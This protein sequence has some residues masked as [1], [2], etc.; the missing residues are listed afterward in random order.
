MNSTRLI[1]CIA[2]AGW[3]LS[4]AQLAQ[5]Q[6]AGEA[7][8]NVSLPAHVVAADGVVSLWADFD[9][10]TDHGIPLYLINKTGK[11]VS[12]E[13]QDGDIYIKQETR[14]EKGEWVRAQ[15]HQYSSCGNSYALRI[16]QPSMHFRYLGYLP[17]NGDDAPI[18]YAMH[19]GEALISNTG[20]GRVN[21]VEIE[22]ARFDGM[23]L[24][25]V[26]R[27]IRNAF[28]PEW[29]SREMK[30]RERG[31]C[32]KLLKVYGPVPAL[33]R[34]AERQLNAWRAAPADPDEKH[35]ADVFAKLLSSGW[36]ET[37]S[38]DRLLRFCLAQ[39]QEGA[40]TDIVASALV[41]GTLRDLAAD[42]F[43]IYHRPSQVEKQATPSDDWKTV[44]L[45]AVKLIQNANREESIGMNGVLSINLLVDSFLPSTS[46]EP[47][48]KVEA[49][50][51]GSQVAAQALSRRGETEH[52]S[53]LALALP[54]ANQLIALA[55]LA[56]GGVSYEQT[57]LDNWM[58]LRRPESGTKEETFW[59]HVMST[60][61]VQASQALRYLSPHDLGPD[62]YG[63]I[64][65][66]GLRSFWR[67][68][69]ERS[70]NLKESFALA[71]PAYS[72][73]LS[74]DFLARSK[75]KEDAALFRSLLSYRGYEFEEGTRNVSA[76]GIMTP[77]KKQR[78]GVR[79]AALEALKAIGEQ[80]PSDVVLE[81][82]ISDPMKVVE[83]T[84]G[85]Q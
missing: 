73:R 63:S 57:G 69:S 46:L 40:M 76:N 43:G 77:Y 42:A 74:V 54:A 29:R 68:E 80:V 84:N 20:Q 22:G 41:W 71:D 82:D 16:L 19:S 49:H 26:P 31:D 12:F 3:N 78:F 34:E 60:Q 36:E 28:D 39:A 79:H 33:R 64:V 24:R 53:D 35:A 75:R 59:K 30:P 55:A 58:G 83:T 56:T 70:N 10:G 5:R 25:R 51:I 65:M 85:G 9:L 4:H 21:S 14:N 17:A 15:R 62:V 18:R 8:A 61:P 52:L 7:L 72:L 38:P 23:S 48:L 32:L 37:V 1:T 6:Y 27:T 66:E 2:L 44:T 67:T 45:L 13:S 50:V 81:R 11:P 47:L